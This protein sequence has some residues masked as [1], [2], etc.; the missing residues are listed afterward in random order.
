MI[1]LSMIL[2][3]VSTLVFI[4]FVILDL[5][6]DKKEQNENKKEK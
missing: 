5:K 6:E 3:I 4:G 2:A 1:L